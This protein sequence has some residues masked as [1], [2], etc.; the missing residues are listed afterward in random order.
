MTQDG[1]RLHETVLICAPAGRDA[2]LTAAALRGTADTR[3]FVDVVSLC[4]ALPGAGAAIIASEAFD[5]PALTCLREALAAQPAWSDL[6]IIVFTTN[7]ATA[8]ENRRMLEVLASLDGNITALERPVHALTMANAV[9][10]A[11]RV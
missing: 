1:E 11:L 4:D 10:A 9:R 3:I 8:S 2:A 6:P 7:R 5:R